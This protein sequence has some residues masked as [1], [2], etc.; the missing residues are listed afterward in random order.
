M[1]ADLRDA[2]LDG[3]DLRGA[4][5]MDADLSGALNFNQT[6]N[7]NRAFWLVTTCP[8][9]SMNPGTQRCRETF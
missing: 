6:I 9:G 8:D 2:M 1:D 3:A 5:L 7:P 4:D